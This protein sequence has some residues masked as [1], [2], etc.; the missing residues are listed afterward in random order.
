MYMLFDF[1]KNL[2]PH[3]ECRCKYTMTNKFNV[4]DVCLWPH[5]C[6]GCMDA[7]VRIENWYHTF[8]EEKDC[9]TIVYEF[10]DIYRGYEYDGVDE[11]YLSLLATADE[12]LESVSPYE[13]I[14]GEE[15]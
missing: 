7:V 1:L 5:E 11:K 6:D 2:F 8:D 14:N 4:G 12:M 15:E 3:Y 10:Y 9:E 13:L